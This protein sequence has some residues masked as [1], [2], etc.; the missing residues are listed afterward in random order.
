MA[1]A[2][3]IGLLALIGWVVISWVSPTR[4]A[5]S[6]TVTV[7]QAMCKPL[8]H[9]F[10]E[11]K[12]KGGSLTPVGAKKFKVSVADQT[13]FEE[14]DAPLGPFKFT[15]CKVMDTQNWSCTVSDTEI[16]MGKGH[17]YDNNDHAMQFAKATGQVP[18]SE[19]AA[20]IY[21]H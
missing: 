17:Y 19:V 20:D 10:W 3:R 6:D 8:N 7:C 18:C 9:E 1:M 15:S 5:P 13:V 14:R 16:G 11:C 21:P 4:S 2:V 12:M